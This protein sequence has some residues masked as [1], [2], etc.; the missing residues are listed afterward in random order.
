MHHALAGADRSYTARG[1]GP[2]ARLLATRGPCPTAL[3]SLADL[4]MGARLVAGLPRVLRHPIPIDTARATLRRRLERREGDF[5]DLVRW[6]VYAE[7]REPVPRPAPAGRLRARGPR[8]AGHAAKAS[9]GPSGELYAR[10]VYLTVDELKGRH[11]VVRGSTSIHV[12]PAGLLSPRLAPHLLSQTSGSRG[13]RSLVPVNLPR[14]HRPGCRP[15]AGPGRLP[16]ARLAPGLLG[17][18]RR[19]RARPG[20]RVRRRRRRGPPM[21]LAHRPPGARAAPALSVERPRPPAGPGPGRHD[22]AAGPAPREAGPIPCRSSAGWRRCWR[23]GEMPHVMSYPSAV[24]R[25]CRAAAETGLDLGRAVFTSAGEP[26]TSARLGVIERTGARIIPRYSSV[27][28]GPIGYGC[29]ARGAPDDVHV[30]RDLVALVQPSAASRRPR[31]DRAHRRHRF[32]PDSLLL[33]TLRASAPLILINASLG[34]PGGD[35]RAPLRMPAGVAGLDDAPPGD[36]EPRE[37]HRRRDDLPRHR[38]DPRPRGG[39]A[40]ALWRSADRLPAGRGGRRRAAG[41]RLRLLVHPRHRERST[42]RPWPR[43]SCPP[44]APGRAASASMAL[45]WRESKFLRVERQPPLAGPSGKIQHLHAREQRP[46]TLTG[47]PAG[48]GGVWGTL[49]GV[50]GPGRGRH[51]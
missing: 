28:S 43:P 16:G 10:G 13:A 19:E 20:A 32:L 47:P 22:A 40:G 23:R 41:P 50:T 2:V 4:S 14:R 21:V 26:M 37:A 15:R 42:P 9:R 46:S 35:E 38:P 51:P 18:A 11:A 29:M 49:G 33:S 6:G 3:L 36:P 1:A 7:S 5:L 34:R 31:G 25:I 8:A 48:P 24:V 27:E 17:G 39:A 30:L 45:L 44:S 12:D